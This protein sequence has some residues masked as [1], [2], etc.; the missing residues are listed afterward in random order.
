MELSGEVWPL[1]QIQ[2]WPILCAGKA[3]PFAFYTKP[4][5]KSPF[6]R[7]RWEKDQYNCT[8]R[9]ERG[10]VWVAEDDKVIVC[11]A[12]DDSS[13]STAVRTSLDSVKT[14]LCWEP[15]SLSW[16]TG[17]SPLQTE[18]SGTSWADCWGA[19]FIQP[20]SDSGTVNTAAAFLPFQIHPG[21][22]HFTE[23]VGTGRGHGLEIHQL[24]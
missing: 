3:I 4:K 15:R 20:L 10:V 13:V 6:P 17:M 7:S 21:F 2:Y 8:V 19:T 18:G 22:S 5:K 11:S 1:L 12:A 14:S 24:K 9:G 16:W 23:A